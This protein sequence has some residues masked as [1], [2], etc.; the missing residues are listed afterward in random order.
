MTDSVGRWNKRGNK[1]IKLEPAIK[2]NQ[3]GV[4]NWRNKTCLTLCEDNHTSRRSKAILAVKLTYT[5]SGRAR[6][7]RGPGRHHT[8]SRTAAVH[9]SACLSD[10]GAR[11]AAVRLGCHTAASILT[12]STTSSIV[13]YTRA[14]WAPRIHLKEA[15]SLKWWGWSSC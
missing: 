3:S 2:L 6:T 1:R 13:C 5:T 11:G 9:A 4:D 14:P 8:G 7:P 10:C 12:S 15:K